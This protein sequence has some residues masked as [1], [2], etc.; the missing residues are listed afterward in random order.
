V[1]ASSGAFT[2]NRTLYSVVEAWARADEELVDRSRVPWDTQDR[3]PSHA[4]KRTAWPREILRSEI[5]T[6]VGET[7]E[8]QEFQNLT[9]RLLDLAA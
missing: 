7:A 9:R 3:R 5:Q 4:D 2:V 6:V 8:R 1:Y